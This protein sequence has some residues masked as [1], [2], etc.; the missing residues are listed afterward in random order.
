MMI[1]I[2]IITITEYIILKAQFWAGL[3]E[4]RLI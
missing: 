4:A 2:I 1:I 3:F